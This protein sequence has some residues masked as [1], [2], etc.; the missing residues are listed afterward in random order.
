[1]I[2]FM[3][4]TYY[5][6]KLHSHKFLMIIFCSLLVTITGRCSKA[7]TNIMIRVPSWADGATLSWGSTPPVSVPAGKLYESLCN[8]VAVQIA[9]TIPMKTR[10]SRRFNNAASIYRG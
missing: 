4:N 7:L 9:L 1:M 3:H 8:S 6:T 2:I 5:N 10:V